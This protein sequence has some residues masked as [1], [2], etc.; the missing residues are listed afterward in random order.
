MIRACPPL[1]TNS[2]YSSLLLCAHFAETCVVAERDRKIVGWISAYFPPTEPNS[3]FVWQV[4][5]DASARGCGLG[6]QML[7]ELM[8]RRAAQG[9]IALTTT[10][11]E[12]NDAS[13]ALFGS[14]ARRHGADLQ[15]RPMFERD[16]HFAG[17][18]DTEFLVSITP[19]ATQIKKSAKE[20]L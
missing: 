10:I 14:F 5:V 12:T 1:D 6:R 16:V 18:H 9:V 17:E 20:I 13:W 8:S 11:T 3:I 2:A 19:L 7:D 15:Q 4:A